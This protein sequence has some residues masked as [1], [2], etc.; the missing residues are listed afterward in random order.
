LTRKRTVGSDGNPF[1]DENQ[2]QAVFFWT[3]NGIFLSDTE[4]I[5]NP[6]KS[7]LALDKK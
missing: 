7:A 6:E 3:G 1:Q 5:K 2:N 4:E